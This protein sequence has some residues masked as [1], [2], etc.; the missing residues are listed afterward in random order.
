MTFEPIEKQGYYDGISSLMKDLYKE[1]ISF[2]KRSEAI[3]QRVVVQHNGADWRC[4]H[5]ETPYGVIL[6]T[7][8]KEDEHL[9]KGQSRLGLYFFYN[10]QNGNEKE[11]GEKRI[12]FLLT[13]ATK[14][15]LPIPLE[16]KVLLKN[17]QSVH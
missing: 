8:L 11:K 6:V 7:L 3:D 5:D 2:F 4:F 9:K 10:L 12:S 15:N 17:P 13:E 1:W 16:L 14:K